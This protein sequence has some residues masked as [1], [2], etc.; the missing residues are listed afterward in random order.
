MTGGPAVLHLER[1][2]DAPP[3]RI[4]AAWTDPALLRRWW[5]AE[6]DWTGSEAATDVRVGGRY[7]L[8]MRDPS[9]T[10]R[11]VV[12][13]Y[14]EVDPPRRLVYTWSWEAH[15]HSSPGS[16]VTIVTVDFV[17]EGPA[18]RVVLQQRGFA[19]ATDRDLHDAGWRGCLDNLER[20]V[21][22]RRAAP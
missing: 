18:T 3:E 22:T 5:A 10:V 6:P 7:R 15:D 9:G 13:E 1:L 8:S 2:L 14:L 20:R 17:P 12:G 16:D 4:F 11:S 21:I 19:R